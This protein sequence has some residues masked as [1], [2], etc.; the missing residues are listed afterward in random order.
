MKEKS[1]QEYS[2]A[3]RCLITEEVFHEC[4]L[5]TEAGLAFCRLLPQDEKF[6]GLDT[7]LNNIFLQ[8]RTAV[9]RLDSPAETRGGVA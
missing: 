7:I 9:N 4:I 2:P 8:I 1:A 5:Q 3:G 6:D